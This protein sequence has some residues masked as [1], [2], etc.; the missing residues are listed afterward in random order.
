MQPRYA[1]G[2]MVEFLRL[3]KPGGVL[4][5]QLPGEPRQPLR[6]LIQPFK[7]LS[8]FRAYQ[9]LRYGDQPIME[10]YSIPRRQV[11]RLLEAHG[12]RVVAVHEDAS[13]DIHWR[14]YRYYV[15]AA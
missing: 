5:F 2:Y 4:V 7:S 14:S 3:L 1:K 8:L 12:G 11:T 9:R 10:M 15:A 6:R 13:A